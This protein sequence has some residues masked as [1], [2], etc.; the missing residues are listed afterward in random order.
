M[1]NTSPQVGSRPNAQVIGQV[2]SMARGESQPTP[3]TIRS[4]VDMMMYELTSQANIKALV[5][6]SD[7]PGRRGPRTRGRHESTARAIHVGAEQ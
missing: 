3:A 4:F 5:E 6:S 7:K 2:K 1:A